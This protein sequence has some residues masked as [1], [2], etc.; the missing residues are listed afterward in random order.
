MQIL[1]RVGSVPD[2]EAGRGRRDQLH[3]PLCIRWRAGPWIEIRFGLDNRENEV[4]IQTVVR[5]QQ[6]HPRC[7]LLALGGI[8]ID[9]GI[10]VLAGYRAM[11]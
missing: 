9:T 3:Q 11:A 4:R 2:T 10:P 5:R 8:R 7:D 1:H 6:A